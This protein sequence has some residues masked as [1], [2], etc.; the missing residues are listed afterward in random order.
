MIWRMTKKGQDPDIWGKTYFKVLHTQ[1]EAKRNQILTFFQFKNEY[2]N[3]LEREN[4]MKIM[5]HLPIMLFRLFVTRKMLKT[6]LQADVRKILF[7]LVHF[8][9][10]HLKYLVARYQKMVWFIG[11]GATIW[12]IP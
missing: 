11:F 7:Q 4:Q 3:Q 1:M 6:D 10:V 5:G 2:Y 9:P 8:N 12:D